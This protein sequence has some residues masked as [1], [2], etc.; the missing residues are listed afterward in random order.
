MKRINLHLGEEENTIKVR[1]IKRI[2]KKFVPI[3]LVLGILMSLAI[4]LVTL[5]GSSSVVNFIMNSNNLKS[6]NNR[7]NI[8]LL[9]IAGGTHD[10]AY[11]TDTI[12]VASYN[13]KLNKVYL[14]SIPRDLWLPS[15]KAKANAVYQIGLS[16]KNG[17]NLTKTVMGNILGLTIH[18]GL[19]VDFRGFTKAIDDLGGIDVMVD[20]SFDD[21]NYP[22]EGKEND[23]C[24]WQ[25]EEKDFNEEEAKKLNI[26]LGK[27][28]VLIKDDTI[29]TDSAEEDRGAKYF[30]CRF[31]L[32][33]FSQGLAHMDGATALKFVRSRHGTNGEASDFARS[34]RQQRVIESIRNKTLSFETLFNP[35]R[36]SELI[37]IF[38]KSIDTDIT[39]KE[40]LEF[41][42]LSKKFDSTYSFVL[43]DS[44]K[45]GLP[46]NRKSLLVRPQASDYGGAYLLI[47]QDDDF[48]IV[49]GYVRKVLSGEITEYEATAA[50]RP[51][52][53]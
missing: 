18:Y 2:L 15:L 3:V 42:K 26:E 37:K 51:R 11:L 4:F 1:R 38:D 22:I 29:A 34:R 16:Q 23:L 32:I 7:V 46:G 25:E 13:L 49:Q 44:P 39:V 53:N 5:S 17:L 19:R 9:G 45:V 27:R 48:S 6:S 14:I 52:S 47:S 8:L 28:K 31:E 35:S 12:V 10:G 36:I 24:G 40:I 50:A 41:Y 43:D 33:S 30:S 20:K 21:P